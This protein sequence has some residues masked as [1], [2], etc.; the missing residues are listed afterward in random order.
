MTPKAGIATTIKGCPASI[1]D[2]FIRYHQS[3]GF[4]YFIFFLD[5]PSEEAPLV[6]PAANVQFVKTD[7]DLYNQW[8][9]VNRPGLLK[10][11][12]TDII[13]RQILNLEVAF[14][15]FRDLDVKWA[16]HIDVD[17]IFYSIR[18]DNVIDHFIELDYNNIYSVNYPNFEA[19]PEKI[20]IES[21]YR[22]VTLF[23]RNSSLLTD[24]Q[25]D[26]LKVYRTENPGR[27]YFN[28]YG[29]GKPAG[30]IL[31]N[32]FPVGP[33][34]FSNSMRIKSDSN[35]VILHYPVCGL[36]YFIDKYKIL[37][38]FP[39]TWLGQHEIAASLP[40]HVLSRDT[41][42]ATNMD[43]VIGLYK[44]NVMLDPEQ[45][46]YLLDKGIL[47]RLRDVADRLKT[48]V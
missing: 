27:Q 28:F 34:H 11:I 1:L 35:V 6:W 37:G 19:I 17:E 7:R 24:Y 13:A 31:G 2:E 18:W 21:Y 33:H 46:A 10:Y 38:S 5:D 47:V 30:N 15:I 16:V 32:I 40:F 25:I 12:E 42:G 41:I 20:N 43:E 39:D 44:N 45:I 26:A 4:A 8:Q 48:L 22:D 9:S 23:K 36:Q 3:I 29:N 14:R